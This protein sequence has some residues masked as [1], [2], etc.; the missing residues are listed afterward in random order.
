LELLEENGDYN[1]VKTLK[2]MASFT[3]PDLP[4]ETY[5]KNWSRVLRMLVPFGLNEFHRKKNAD[6]IQFFLL[7]TL[8]KSHTVSWSEMY[9][10][11]FADD[12]PSRLPSLLEGVRQ[13]DI[14]AQVGDG[15]EVPIFFVCGRYD[16]Q[17]H[18]EI[19]A[20]YFEQITAPHKEMLMLE[21]SAHSI[22]VDGPGRFFNFL[23]NKVLPFA[24]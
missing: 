8:L 2:A 13:T 16:W 17:V 9:R 22:Y 18:Y 12:N 20:G 10:D 4:V 19:S 14:P 5:Y 6:M 24:S 3:D 11:V 7:S 23:V 15:F 21:N 1:G